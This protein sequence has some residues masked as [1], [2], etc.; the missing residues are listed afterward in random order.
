MKNYVYTR[1]SSFAW[2]SLYMPISTH[3][4][5]HVEF[6]L[7]NGSFRT[8]S[9]PTNIKTKGSGFTFGD[10]FMC[11]VNHYRTENHLFYYADSFRTIK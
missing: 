3:F 2:R 8:I 5:A 4:R 10:R 6:C 11:C 9:K 1:S 7:N